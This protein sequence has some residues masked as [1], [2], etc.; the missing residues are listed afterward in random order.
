MKYKFIYETKA[1]DL[2]KLS[3]YGVY[4]SMVGILNIIFTVAMVLL[5]T[6]FWGEVNIFIKILL[7]MA[8]SLFTII[9]PAAVYMRAKSHVATVPYDMEIGFDDNGI[10]I[11]TKNE[12]SEL[13][14]NTIK[15]VFKKQN[16]IVILTT[17]KHGFIIKDNML[18]TEK[19]DFYKYVVSKINK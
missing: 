9:Q 16:M 12:N 7:V 15:G 4:G 17:N 1:F 6:K 14:W 13:K 3:M 2:W 11:K 18:G 19:E 10:Y 8:V 5:T